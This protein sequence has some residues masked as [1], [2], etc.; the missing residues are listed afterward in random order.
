MTDTVL[1]LAVLPLKNTVVFPELVMPLAVGR[2]KSLAAVKAA[3][4][5]NQQLLTVAQRN[6]DQDAP[7][8][9]EIHDIGT[10]VE[11]KRVERREGGAQV[12]V[13]GIQRVRVLDALANDSH[14]VVRYVPLPNLVVD[15]H[16]PDAPRVDA[17]IRENLE[18]AR[19]IAQLFDAENG[20]QVFHQMI[21]SITDPV[22]Q[23]Y[24][25]ASIATQNDVDKEQEVLAAGTTL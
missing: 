10:L 3:A 2:P 24:R 19:H 14:L 1:S 15:D 12:I 11:I 8:R 7:D 25:I 21:G 16:D 4:E 13:Q 23:M 17:L 9:A 5:V 20:L 22:V 18:L 6:A